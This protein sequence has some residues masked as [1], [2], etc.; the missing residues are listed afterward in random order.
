[1]VQRKPQKMQQVSVRIPGPIWQRLTAATGVLGKSQ[2]WIITAA[3]QYY[4]DTFSPA[5]RK[6]ME[7][8]L[9]Q[10]DKI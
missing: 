2:A 9:A 3:L 7:D 10:R 6:L 5:R 8:V 1:M 4:F